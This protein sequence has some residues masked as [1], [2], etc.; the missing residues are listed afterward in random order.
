M[1]RWSELKQIPPRR[2]AGG[3]RAR[4]VG[5]V[6]VL[7]VL[8]FSLGFVSG[9]QDEMLLKIYRGIDVFGKVYK[10]VSLNYVDSIDPDAFIHAGIDGML[11]TLDPY[12]VFIGEHEGDEIDLV[13][14]GKY[15]GIGVTISIRDGQIIIVGLMEGFS[16][17]RQGLQVGDRIL[18]I[19]STEITS[20]NFQQVRSLV[21][22]APGTE[23]RMRIQRE[24]EP[25]PLEFVLLREEITVK[26]VSYAGFVEDGVGYIRLD[27]FSRTAGDDLRNAIRS[28]KASGA[29]KG[30][31]LDVRDNPG[32]L[33][34]MAVDVVSKFVPEKSLVVSTRGRSPDSERKYYSSETPMLPDVPMAVLVNEGSASASEIVAGAMQDLDRGV[35]VGN[36]TFGKGL[37]QTITRLSETTSLKITTARYYTPSDRCIQILDY[38]HHNQDGSPVRVTDTL[39]EEYRT[40]KNRIVYGGGGILPDSVVSEGSR[41]KLL[42][43]LN[44][45]AMIFSFAN[46]YAVR[47]KTLPDDFVV[48]DALLKEFKQYLA[49]K[50]FVYEEEAES[51]IAELKQFA[52]RDRYSKEFVDE[53]AHLQTH[54]DEEKER[55]FERFEAEIREALNVEIRG[56]LLGESARVEATFAGDR[57]LQTALGILTNPQVYGAMLA[58]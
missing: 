30:V 7:A 55:A 27:R 35:I 6:L 37:V 41:S 21:R 51:R 1:K 33:L 18:D 56:R 2:R 32:G 48:T 40:S 14:N 44:R 9:N 13:T 10:E 50:N 57:Q 46:R 5:T 28:L 34:D 47:E 19:D 52:S 49:E 43:T 8:A 36:R 12:T 16:A 25:E 58:P 4:T 23:I 29:L 17:A 53:L 3:G 15:G 11:E 45:K 22:G 54:I 20:E 24:E 38:A 42:E 26:N 31:I 39:R